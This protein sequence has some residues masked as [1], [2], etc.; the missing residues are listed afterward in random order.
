MRDALISVEVFKKRLAQLCLRSN[1]A[2]LPG[3]QRDRQIVLKSIVLYLTKQLTYSERDLNAALMRWADDVGQS[4]RVDH[5]A[6]RRALV[7]EKYL[8]RSPGG[9]QYRLVNGASANLFAPD[10]DAID[11][12]LVIQDALAEAA[13]KKAQ[14]QDRPPR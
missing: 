14:Y 9:E 3:R 13:A 10:V 6:L 8:E 12:A 7:D 2:E 5:A 1:S 4:L 11:S